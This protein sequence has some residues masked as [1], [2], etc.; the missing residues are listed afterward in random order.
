MIVDTATAATRR[1]S[2]IAQARIQ[3]AIGNRYN[4][5][6]T[7]TPEL[8][9][10]QIDQ[11]LTGRLRS[12]A[13]VMDAVEM[14]DPLV[15]TVV[16]KRKKSVARLPWEILTVEDADEKKAGEHRETLLRF[17]NTV[18][19]TDVLTQ[20]QSGGLAL[21]IRQMMDAQGKGFAVHEMVFKPGQKLSA[22]F[23][24]APLW[25][26]EGLTGR[27]RYLDS[28][29][30]YEGQ[31]LDPE[32]WLVSVG[33]G[34]MIPTVIAY[35]F[36][37]FPLRDWLSFCEKFG[38]P[39]VLGS[40]DGQPGS[41]AWT[42]ME[43]A[44]AAVVNDWAGVKGMNDKI[45]LLQAGSGQNLP[46]LPL[47]EYMDR[48]IASL[49]RGAD[50][51][52]ISQGGESS[53]ASLQGDETDMLLEDDAAWVQETLHE[54]VS[55]L[56]IRYQHGDEEPLAYLS[57]TCPKRRQIDADDKAIRL[58]MDAGI[59]LGVDTTRE[60]LGLPKPDA[61]DEVLTASASIS[62]ARPPTM[63]QDAR[64]PRGGIETA[65]EA[66][67]P[68]SKA[69]NGQ[70]ERLAEASRRQF[71]AAVAADLA[72]LRRRLAAIEAISDPE[73]RRARLEAL[74]ADWDTLV[75]DITSDPEAA[76]A[77]SRIQGAALA[78]GL[79]ART[80]T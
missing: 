30:A 55:K 47:V 17:W 22:E 71:A 12:L 2:L 15:K 20:D 62:E 66:E 26:F 60:K 40:V 31:P 19:A 43:T 25:W 75:G 11:Y 32:G 35:V 10:S 80:E 9:G 24:F 51:S 77:L 3:S 38:L 34:L 33:D 73:I 76:D 21:L 7:L 18:R 50:L 69:I 44:V 42:A 68:R 14:R 48:K 64:D 36:K 59:P 4:P 41:E 78:N 65:N 37:L 29:A 16:A 79:A 63:P 53:G 13:L 74:V 49:W 23:R 27:L 6:R 28:D 45:E 57:L 70:S 67:T 46:F 58:C 39:G 54:R 61:E 52:T 72:P 5:I 56:V 1:K 8:L